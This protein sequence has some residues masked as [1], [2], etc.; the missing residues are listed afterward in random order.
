ML[1][2]ITAWQLYDITHSV[3]DPGL[4]GLAQFPPAFT[5]CLVASAMWLIAM[6]GGP[7]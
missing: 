1:V 7:S 5:L 6:T 4:V 2:I 3:C